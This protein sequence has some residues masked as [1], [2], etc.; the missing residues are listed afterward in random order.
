MAVDPRR[1]DRTN[2][3]DTCAVWNVLSSQRLYGSALDA[4]CYFACTGYVVYECL[5]KTR[6]ASSAADESLKER[7]CR[8]QERGRFQEFHVTLD[9]FL[10]VVELDRG[11]KLGSGE[12]SS[13]AFAR[14]HRQ[15]F[16]TDDQ[17]ARR[18]AGEVWQEGVVQT[19]PQ[20]LG[21]LFYTGRLFDA[22][23]A[24]I[25]G[26]HEEAGRALGRYFREM[27]ERALECRLQDK[28]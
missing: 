9:E 21:W 13:L 12:L 19:T 6:K 3:T 1:F 26:E 15:A 16:L 23:I 25:V 8:E 2:V 4:R 10:E 14:K 27:Y 28:K 17:K 24:R 7:L 11:R 20:M 22:D 18:F 5:K